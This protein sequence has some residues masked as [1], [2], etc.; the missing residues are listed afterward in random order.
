[1]LETV[2]V[3]G[4]AALVNSGE[5]THARDQH[6]DYFLGYAEAVPPE[7]TYLDPGG[8]VRSEENNL[9]AALA[10]SDHQGR[11][12]L[13]GRLASTMNRVWIGDIRAGQRW[14]Q[15]AMDGLDDLDGAA[16]ALEK[17]SVEVVPGGE[18]STVSL[19]LLAGLRH[20]KDEHTA[21]MAAA[22]EAVGRVRLFPQSG[23]WAWALYSSLPYALELGHQ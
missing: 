15:A 5:E 19:A 8:A 13:V 11:P 12:D 3:F 23:L 16:E 22:T 7:L 2:R 21:A 9:R 14:L 20:L 10:W 18:M 6:R 17:G 4:E 1:M